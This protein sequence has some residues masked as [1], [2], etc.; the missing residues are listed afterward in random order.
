M[1]ARAEVQAAREQKAAILAATRRILSAELHPGKL[2]RKQVRE[3]LEGEF[4][5]ELSCWKGAI[6]QACKE[7][8]DNA[9]K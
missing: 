9:P 3:R 6:K 8:L 7:F 5:R 1:E 4:G 2:T